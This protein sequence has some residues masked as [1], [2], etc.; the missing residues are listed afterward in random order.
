M[1][2]PFAWIT[3]AKQK[4]V[5]IYLVALTLAVMG[6]LQLL[7]QPLATEAAPGGIISYEFAGDLPTARAILD[8]WGAKGQVSAGLNLGLDFLF[9]LAYAGSIG[10]G[11]V[12][13]ARKLP[14]GGLAHKIGIGLA[15]GLPLAALL[16][17]LENYALIRLLLGSELALWPTVAYWCAIPKFT[18]VGLGLLFVLIGGVAGLLRR[19]RG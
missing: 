18:L 6:C 11:C 10:L 19:G 16:D 14:P 5:F 7:G 12:R 9:L 3:P 4:P 2:T 1:Q 13:V 17:G 15:W 8:S